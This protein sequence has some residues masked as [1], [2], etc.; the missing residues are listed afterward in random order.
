MI[1]GEILTLE[2]D[3]ALNVKHGTQTIAVSNSGDRPIQVGS[4][5]HFSR[6]TTR[7]SLIVPW[8]AACAQY[9][10][11]NGRA[12]RT[13]TVAHG[14]PCRFGR[15][16]HGVWLSG[17]SDG[18]AGKEV[19]GK[20][21]AEVSDDSKGRHDDEDDGQEKGDGDEGRGQAMSTLLPPRLCRD[22]RPDHW[23]SGSPCR[24]RSFH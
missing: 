6:P 9:R 1:P 3:I 15:Q 13:R 20:Q 4:H 21:S 19:K 5:Y 11:R 8:R 2:G 17:S 10:R 16:P 18:A 7:C 12:L 23:G 22:V 24:H 14:G